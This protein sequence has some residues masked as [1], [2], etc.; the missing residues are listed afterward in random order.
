M[1][2]NLLFTFVFISLEAGLAKML[3]EPRALG[4]Y[5]DLPLNNPIV[6]LSANSLLAILEIELTEYFSNE[7]FEFFKKL[8][9]FLCYQNL[10]PNKHFLKMRL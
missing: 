5:S 2:F 4:P 9:L 8:I 3:L 7:K 10:V 6:L 1:R